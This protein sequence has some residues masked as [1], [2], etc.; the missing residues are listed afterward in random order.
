MKPK[1]KDFADKRE[2]W[3]AIALYYEQKSAEYL[4][5]ANEIR[6]QKLGLSWKDSI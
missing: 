3:K 5:K 4:Q 2:Y 6:E 1:P